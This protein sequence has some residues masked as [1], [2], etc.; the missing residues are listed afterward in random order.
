MYRKAIDFAG[1]PL[2]T[3]GDILQ[4]TDYFREDEREPDDDRQ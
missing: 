3:G 2:P 1:L 4:E